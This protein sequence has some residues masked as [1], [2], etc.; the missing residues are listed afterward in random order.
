MHGYCVCVCGDCNIRGNCIMLAL[1]LGMDGWPALPTLSKQTFWPQLTASTHTYKRRATSWHLS[2]HWHV[3]PWELVRRRRRRRQCKHFV[4]VTFPLWTKGKVL[5]LKSPH[6]TPLP[7]LTLPTH[8]PLPSLLRSV[9]HDLEFLCMISVLGIYASQLRVIGNKGKKS[10]GVQS[11]DSN[12]ELGWVLKQPQ[13]R[14]AI[15]FILVIKLSIRPFYTAWTS[16]T[17]DHT[18]K[19]RKKKKSMKH[20]CRQIFH[21]VSKSQRVI[22][23]T[24]RQIFEMV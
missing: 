9:F 24:G 12:T 2:G 19:K 14:M 13:N 15:T 7:R 4:K 18:E 6:H 22:Q 5:P 17:S 3:L 8:K 16:L 20:P 23:H 11:Q 1:R 10:G 21:L